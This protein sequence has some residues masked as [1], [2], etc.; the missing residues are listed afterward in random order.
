MTLKLHFL[1]CKGF[2]VGVLTGICNVF[3]NFADGLK[4]VFLF[5]KCVFVA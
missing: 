1:S 2:F 4:S 5:I 3:T